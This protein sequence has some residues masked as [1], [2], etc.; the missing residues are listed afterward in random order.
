MKNRTLNKNLLKL[1]HDALNFIN[2]KKFK[3]ADKIRG[4]NN[5]KNNPLSKKKLITNIYKRINLKNN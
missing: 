4:K 3:D 5:I 2:C 1:G